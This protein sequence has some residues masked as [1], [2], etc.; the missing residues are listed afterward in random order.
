MM[1][2]S[3]A[4]DV[5]DLHC[6]F[7]NEISIPITV[8]NMTIFAKNGQFLKWL[9]GFL[10]QIKN[11][12]HFWTQ[13]K[14]WVYYEFYRVDCKKAITLL[15][16]IKKCTVGSLAPTLPNCKTTKEVKDILYFSGLHGLYAKCN[17]RQRGLTF[18]GELVRFEQFQKL[19]KTQMDIYFVT[20]SKEIRQE[21]DV[22][23]TAGLIGSVGGSLGMFFG[24]SIAAYVLFALDKC[25]SKL[26]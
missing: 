7:Q 1:N 23:T 26:N 18:S 25:I 17:K 5:F 20:L 24:F 12:C 2:I 21:V 16:D 10:D 6:L 13:H 19:S 4:F 9:Q 14:K 3:V 15:K 11:D 8:Q 22:I